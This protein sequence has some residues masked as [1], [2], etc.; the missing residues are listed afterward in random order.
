MFGSAGLPGGVLRPKDKKFLAIPLKGV[1]RGARP[2]DFEETFIQAGGEIAT[3]AKTGRALSMNAKGFEKFT[4]DTG[5]KG[6]AVIFQK[7]ARGFR[8]LFLLLASVTI[9]ARPF[10]GIGPR[11]R[12]EMQDLTRKHL[13]GEAA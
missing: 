5:G 13:S 10:V 2:K 1:A 8:P 7:T 11:E 3:S 9:P 4:G 6:K 12:Q